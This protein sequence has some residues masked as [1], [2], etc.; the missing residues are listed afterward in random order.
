MDRILTFIILIVFN[1]CFC[2]KDNS[3]VVYP[4]GEQAL[5]DFIN[6]NYSKTEDFLSNYFKRSEVRIKFDANGKAYIQKFLSDSGEEDRKEISSIIKKMP[7]WKKSSKSSN[8]KS[9][10]KILYFPSG[11]ITSEYMISLYRRGKPILMPDVM[12]IP[13]TKD[14]NKYIK[15]RIKDG[16]NRG[17]S[18][19][20][21][22]VVNRDGTLCDFNIVR[23]TQNTNID[24]DVIRIIKQMPK[25][26]PAIF[27]NE[28]VR[29]LYYVRYK[30]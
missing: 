16:H 7:K 20:I 6:M 12:P 8:Y 14:F 24:R 4:G 5:Y 28:K 3:S 2:I 13:S 18:L 29:C 9:C 15:S 19:L 26:K 27:N 1:L 10:S 30:Y 25:W 22:F 23:H 21:S 11:K 17:G